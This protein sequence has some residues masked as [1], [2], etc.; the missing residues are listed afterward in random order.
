MWAW[1]ITELLLFAGLF[2]CALILR[3]QH[4]ESVML[5]TTHLKFWIGATN[6]AVLICS[7]LTMSLAIVTSRLVGDGLCSARCWQPLRLVPCS[8]F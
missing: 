5:V 7:S 4:P 8:C 6:T 1:L 3:I 2:L